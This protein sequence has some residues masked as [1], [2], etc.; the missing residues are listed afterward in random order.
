[1]NTSTRALA[2]LAVTQLLLLIAIV[3][4][5]L[6]SD[7]WYN[8]RLALIS[9]A[10]IAPFALIVLVTGVLVRKKLT[11]QPTYVA[12]LKRTSFYLLP[13]VGIAV[14][15]GI[16]AS[17]TTIYGGLLFIVTL[18]IGI[19]AMIVCALVFSWTAW[20][21]GKRILKTNSDI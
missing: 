9:L 19:P 8:T 18:I 3:Y 15:I 2:T 12:V 10:V 11:E 21:F 1:M 14:V 5:Y 7:G 20:W 4:T 6:A 16:I 17:V 13:F